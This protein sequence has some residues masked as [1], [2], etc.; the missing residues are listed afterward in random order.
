[1]LARRPPPLSPPAQI[2]DHEYVAEDIAE[3]RGL[4]VLLLD[5]QGN[6][7]SVYRH[8]A[9]LAP[10]TPYGCY[11][12]VLATL[13]CL[14]GDGTI[15]ARTWGLFGG[16]GLCPASVRVHDEPCGEWMAVVFEW[17]RGWVVD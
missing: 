5:V 2:H 14:A 4:R 13:P 3:L 6:I 17:M 10:G 1:M 11:W 12:D 8:S 7:H 15:G 16:K 9:R